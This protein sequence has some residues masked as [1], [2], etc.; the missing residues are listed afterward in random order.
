MMKIKTNSLI[1]FV[2]FISLITLVTCNKFDP[3][4]PT[5]STNKLVVKTTQLSD[6]GYDRAT[7]YGTVEVGDLV[8]ISGCG[9]V[10][11]RQENPD[12]TNFAGKDEEEFGLNSFSCTLTYLTE[13]TT[14]Y[15]RAFATSSE[16]TVYGQQLSFT[17]VA[18]PSL[19]TN[20]VSQVTA[21]TALSG[22]NVLS[23]GGY[24]ITARGVCW[25]TSQS[26]SV[27]D[28][29]TSNGSGTGSFTSSITGLSPSTTYYLRAYATNSLGSYYGNQ[30]SFTT[31]ESTS[32][33]DIRDGTEYLTVQIG[34][35]IWM[36][37]N[38]KYLP[39][40]HSPSAGSTSQK[41][42]YVYNYT[43][44]S[45]SVAKTQEKFSTYGVLYNWVAAQTACPSGWHLPSDSEWSELSNYLGGLSVAGG[46]LKETG[47]THW[48]TPNTA[49][50]NETQFTALP[51]GIRSTSNSFASL[52]NYGFWWS[53]TQTSTT[54]AADYRLNYNNGQVSNAAV[55][56]ENGFSVRCVKD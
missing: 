49:A 28:S 24:T 41:Y 6:I 19:T 20:D 9:F 27:A 53:S 12:I 45:V 55:S 33:I 26:P 37:E 43:G 51:G 22:G 15:V 25:S 56:K 18:A 32:I 13:N 11:S 48:N 39:Y 35:Q 52:G 46:A 14:Y 29:H 2:S 5:S 47:T 54:Y 21:R 42:Y 3:E 23:G 1:A 36:A 7:V 10:W 30:V 17:T 31:E 8:N 4:I 44:V 40:V 50:T 16:K 38:L 34:S